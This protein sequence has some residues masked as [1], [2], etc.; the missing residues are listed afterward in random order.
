MIVVAVVVVIVI[1]VAV[2]AAI[3]SCNSTA[4]FLAEFVFLFAVQSQPHTTIDHVVLLKSRS[5][6]TNILKGN[7][8]ISV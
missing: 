5:K 1:V 7:S 8:S 3:L 6:F 2:T 4:L